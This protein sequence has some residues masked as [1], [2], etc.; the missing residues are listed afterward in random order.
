MK[1]SDRITPRR[2][3]GR[4][5]SFDRDAALHAAMLVFWRH[6]YESTSLGDLTAAMGV[7][8][9]S[10]YAAFGNKKALFLEAVRR[11]VGE[12]AVSERLIAEAASARAAARALLDSAAAGF[13]GTDTPRGCL[14]ASAAAAVSS[15]AA[16]VQVELSAIRAAVVEQLS[17][18]LA[19]G[20]ADGE[21]DPSLDPAAAASHVVA[22][23]QGMSTLARDGATR[24]TLDSIVAQVMRG[25]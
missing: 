20:V 19:R 24:A 1:T 10:I 12:P 17:A 8:P 4:P 23:I 2:R 5:L 13:T 22:V 7:T 14:L 16:D 21:L 15:D 9:P 6:G 25:I 18:R 3:P 11:Y